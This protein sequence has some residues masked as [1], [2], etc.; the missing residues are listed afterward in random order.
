M[1]GAIRMDENQEMSMR[2][3]QEKVAMGEYQVDPA[4]VA[5]AIV[6]RLRDYVRC[7]YPDKLA[8]ESMKATPGSPSSTRPIHEMGDALRTAL[9]ITPRAFRDAQTHSS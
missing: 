2:D 9:S 3:I 5:D 4:A 6:R 8:R 7:S 1:L